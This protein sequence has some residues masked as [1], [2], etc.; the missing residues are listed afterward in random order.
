MRVTSPARPLSCKHKVACLFGY[1]RYGGV[2]H[3]SR[4]AWQH[5][6]VN[7]TQTRNTFNAQSFINDGPDAAGADRVVEGIRRATNEIVL[8]GNVCPAGARVDFFRSP[9]G[10]GGAGADVA[11]ESNAVREDG[12]ISSFRE[13]VGIDA[14]W[15][16][17]VVGGKSHAAPAAGPHQARHEDVRR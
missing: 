16:T 1:F 17:R 13:V 2:D 8:S 14:G 12:E 3:C 10:K 5:R 11:G 7:D 15:S 9:F 4:N 6:G